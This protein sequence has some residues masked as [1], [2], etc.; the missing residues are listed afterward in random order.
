MLSVTQ[1]LFFKFPWNNFLHSVVY[2]MI[3]KVFNT[4]TFIAALPEKDERMTAVRVRVRALVISVC[5]L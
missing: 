1:D 5:P 4:Y 2:D 3:A